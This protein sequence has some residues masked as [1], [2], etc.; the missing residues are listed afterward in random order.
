MIPRSLHY[1][2]IFTCLLLINNILSTATNQE[3]IDAQLVDGAVVSKL[4]SSMELFLFPPNIK[5]QKI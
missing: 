1:I 2:L 3:F 5:Y 4:R